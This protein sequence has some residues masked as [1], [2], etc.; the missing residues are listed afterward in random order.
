MKSSRAFGRLLLALALG[1]G[2]AACGGGGAPESPPASPLRL[3]TATAVT[4]SIG[5]SGGTLTTTAADGTVYTLSVPAKALR[6]LTSITLSPIASIEDLPPG[7]SLAGGAHLTPEGQRFDVPVT[8]EILLANSPSRTAV[9]FSYAG[10]LLQRHRYPARVAGRSIDFEIVH[11]SGYAVLSAV[12]GDALGY[13]PAPSERGD[14]ALQELVDAGLVGLE[15]AARDSARR[16][17]L[18]GWLDDFIKPEV[19]ALAALSAY[20]L[21]A[22]MSGRIGRLANELRTFAVALKF[23]LLEGSADAFVELQNAYQ[24]EAALAA[25]KAIDLSNAGCS[26]V[27][28]QAVLLVAPD[29]LAWQQLAQQAD[30]MVLDESLERP[31][32]LKALCVQPVFDPQNPV[33]FVAEAPGQSA[34]LTAR[35]GYSINDAPARFDLPMLFTSA[36]TSNVTPSNFEDAEVG[37]GQT[38]ARLFQ[39]NA[40]TPSMRIDVSACFAEE[41]LRELCTAQFVVRGAPSTCP[42]YEVTVQGVTDTSHNFF[43][44]AT[45]GF[46][47]TGAYGAATL[48]GNMALSLTS[49]YAGTSTARGTLVYVV[50]AAGAPGSAFDVEWVWS[51]TSDIHLAGSCSATLTVGAVTRSFTVTTTGSDS[52]FGTREFKLPMS[53]RHGDTLSVRL[54]ASCTSPGMLVNANIGMVMQPPGRDDVKFKP[55]TCEQ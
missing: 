22:F 2:I 55:V 7:A 47:Q 11:F 13:F 45:T 31:A 23:A 3:E 5:P 49:A 29:I 4:Q 52:R 36:G 14:R 34:P 32:V 21:D 40:A 15:P 46:S 44:N 25:R 6:A 19:A 24:L 43:E 12:L 26:A 41:S 17:A 42:L 39:W 18:Q 16:S 20:D 27:P 37:A 8:L 28:D 9:P 38:Y 30:A 54:D 10:E 50:E 51:G 48:G 33:T 1:A 35:A 53:V